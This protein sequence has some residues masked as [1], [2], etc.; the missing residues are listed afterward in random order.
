MRSD[1]ET[2]NGITD[3]WLPN[4]DLAGGT[5]AGHAGGVPVLYGN[6]EVEV[7]EILDYSDRSY[8][9]SE[10]VPVY[11]DAYIPHRDTVGSPPSPTHAQ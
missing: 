7:I 6:T 11:M 8:C 4:H 9:V 2:D 10:T 1:A 3:P 5:P